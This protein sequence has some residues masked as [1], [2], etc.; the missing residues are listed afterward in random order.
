[1]WRHIASNALSLFVVIL[2]VIGGLVAWGKAQYSTPG[3][4][5]EAICLRVPSGARMSEVSEDLETRGAISNGSIFRVGT[6]YSG[7]NAQLKAGSFLV[8]Q[9]ASM[10]E[11]VDLITRGGANTCG[12]EVVYRIGINRVDLQVRELDPVTNRFVDV[13]SFDPMVETSEQYT[14]VRGEAD[15]RYRITL[16]EGTTSWQIMQALQAADFIDADTNS[17][18]AEGD[19]APDSYEVSAGAS[20]A[21]LIAD[22]EQAQSI[23]LD[24]AW[25]NRAEGLPIAS[26]EDA[27]ILASIVE[28]ETGLPNER[29][30]VAS[31]FIN[32]LNKGMKLQT[33]PTV[34]YGV[35]NGRGVLGRGLRQSELRKATPYNTYIIAGLPPGPIAN[36]GIEAITA[37]LNPATTDYI[38]FVANGTGGHAFA[39]TLKQHNINVTAWR[40]IEASQSGN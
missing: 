26:R 2:V 12:T 18:P 36:P 30:Q 3:P 10:V 5:A 40:K 16:A 27:L 24:Q 35:T 1:M 39:T 25:A 31:V 17:I 19:L 15:T 38:F 22:M 13:V 9:A 21:D 33:D 8:P 11:I 28:K 32:R 14:K 34:I 20:L 7:K 37:T 6:D 23:R 4:L 29:A